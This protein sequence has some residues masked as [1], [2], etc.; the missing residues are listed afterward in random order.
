M[1]TTVD[2]NDELLRAAKLRAAQQKTSLKAVIEHALRRHLG[3]RDHSEE[4]RLSWAVEDGEM[5]P[6]VD[7][8]DRDALFDLMDGRR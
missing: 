8:T 2:I 4:Y 6:G 3:H 1:R 7:L 5:A